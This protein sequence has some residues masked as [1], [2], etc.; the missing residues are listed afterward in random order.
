MNFLNPEYNLNPI[1]GNSKG[2]KHTPES[3]EKIR[4]A[5]TGRK[6][7]EEVRCEM[8]ESRRGI[9]NPFYGKTHTE[10]SLALIKAAA[11]NRL[12]P[13]VPG[14]EVEITDLETKVTSVYDSIRKAA[15]ALDSDIKTILRREKNQTAKGINTP[16]RGRYLI[17]IKRYI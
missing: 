3:L 14:I 11:A 10:D 2:Y 7:T 6:H 17:N 8:S 1:A 13:G 12:E 16:Y 9:N 15:T 5:A 4:K